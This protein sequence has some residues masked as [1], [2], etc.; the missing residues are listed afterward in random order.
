[1]PQEKTKLEIINSNFS[2]FDADVNP[3]A[4][5][6]VD[7]VIFKH[8]GVTMFCDSAWHYL[9]KTVLKLLVTY[10]LIKGIL[11]TFVWK[12]FRLHWSGK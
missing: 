3:D 8:E 7:S 5:R 1:M 10:I 9:K 6:L 11:T 12:S 4:R 2:Y